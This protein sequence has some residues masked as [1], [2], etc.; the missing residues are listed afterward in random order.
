MVVDPAG[1]TK[2]RNLDADDLELERLLSLALL[3]RRRGLARLQRDAG[4]FTTKE[5]PGIELVW[6]SQTPISTSK[7][8]R[9]K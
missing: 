6:D 2:I 8:A 1:V 7:P 5:I 4:Y 9:R 3:A